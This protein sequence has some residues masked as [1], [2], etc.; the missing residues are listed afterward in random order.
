MKVELVAVRLVPVLVTRDDA[1]YLAP[2][3]VEQPIE[4]S[5]RQW[6][7]AQAILARSIAEAESSLSAQ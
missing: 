2:L 5:A 7:D 6:S 1:G 3:A 4:L